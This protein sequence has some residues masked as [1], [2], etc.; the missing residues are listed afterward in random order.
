VDGLEAIRRLRQIPDFNRLPIITV[1]A[2]ASGPDRGSS[3]AAGADAF[4]PKPVDEHKLFEQIAILLQID[5]LREAPESSSAVPPDVATSLVLPPVESLQ[6]LHQ[7]AVQGNLRDLEQVAAH[8]ARLDERYRPFAEQLASLAERYESK[9][10][11]D[12]LDRH[13][14]ATKMT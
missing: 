13:L 8:L 11:L 4:L 10:I 2:S 7:L 12:L 5:W 6:L 3:E 14:R 1:S 9:A